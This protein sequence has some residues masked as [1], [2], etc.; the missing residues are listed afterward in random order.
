MRMGY[1]NLIYSQG[2]LTMNNVDFSGIYSKGYV[3]K[4]ENMIGKEFSYTTGNVKLINQGF[5]LK[6]EVLEGFLYAKNLKKL[7]IDGIEFYYNLQSNSD[8]S[9]LYFSNIASV[10]IFNCK[11]EFNF[12]SS[13]L[14]MITSDIPDVNTNSLYNI[15]LKSLSFK[16]NTSAVGLFI[17]LKAQLNFLFIDAN[18]T[19]NICQ[20][21]FLSVKIDQS[22]K[23]ENS[24]ASTTIQDINFKGNYIDSMLKFENINN[25]Y[26]QDIVSELNGYIIDINSTLF[27]EL[28]L[29][30]GETVYNL[31]VVQKPLS[32][33]FINAQTKATVHLSEL[34][35]SKNNYTL[36]KSTGPYQKLLNSYSENDKIYTK[37]PFLSIASVSILIIDN[38]RV[39]KNTFYFPDEGK[40][41]LVQ[42]SSKESNTIIS[43]LKLIDF[44]GQIKF[45]SINYYNITKVLA[46]RSSKSNNPLFVFSCSFDSQINIT[47][48]TFSYLNQEIISINSLNK[49]S[50][51]FKF[52][53]IELS[54]SNSETSFISI[55]SS[56]YL[57]FESKNLIY[58]SVF[59]NNYGQILNMISTNGSVSLKR[60]QF[61]NN[62][63][64]GTVILKLAGSSTVEIFN[65][66]FHSNTG[67]NILSVFTNN[68]LVGLFTND[69]SFSFNN[70]TVIKNDAS[71]YQDD[72]SIF[73][74]N[75]NEIG[76]VL[77]GGLGS[78]NTFYNTRIK[79]N[80]VDDNGCIFLTWK[81]SLY[82]K[83][84]LASFNIAE[85][86]G[87][88][89]YSDQ[90]SE[91]KIYQSE[92][93]HN[94]ALKGSVIYMQN[95]HNDESHLKNSIFEFN[96]ASTYSAIVILDSKVKL[97][98]CI[99]SSNYAS[100]WPGLIGTY[101]SEL[102]IFSSNFS[103][104][105]GEGSHLAI[106]SSTTA[107]I[108]KSFFFNKNTSIYENSLTI[109]S[110]NITFN[111]CGF[112]QLKSNTNKIINCASS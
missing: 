98:G 99:I 65:S 4:L 93:Y 61:T 67:E 112:D 19:N 57:T 46:E 3:I 8:K 60:C 28:N 14:I 84:V 24:I 103:D 66:H 96:E 92:F 83:K 78:T 49:Q 82:F 55:D 11:F 22:I 87:G 31:P 69:C 1:K 89:I 79:N 39:T 100:K 111:D 17:N 34:F 35:S 101:N 56:A 106:E 91:L 76:A 43:N 97:T 40:I 41:M 25:L 88:V 50:V 58:N 74:N 63:Y 102:Y 85:N 10:N 110:S 12:G 37:E 77:K 44:S 95:S 30:S 59:K 36:I 53:D 104:Q 38:F 47:D 20:S 15:K 71:I 45:D 52:V 16:N 42:S 81:S 13:A 2:N 68:P 33:I 29:K 51:S 27:S 86:M 70:G 105:T 32:T 72:N 108:S 107:I 64:A 54:N 73:E 6:T 94:K 90:N 75:S 109:S 21:D 18:I 48:A 9:M 80:Q 26:I 5:Q 7:T 62:I 23:N